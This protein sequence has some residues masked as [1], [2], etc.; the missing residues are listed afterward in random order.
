MA[1]AGRVQAPDLNLTPSL[2]PAPIVQGTMIQPFNPQGAGSNLMNIADSL[3]RLGAPLSQFAQVAQAANVKQQQQQAQAD[4]YLPPEVLAANIAKDPS[5]YGNEYYTAMAGRATANNLGPLIDQWTTQEW[6]STKED[7][8]TFVTRK[9]A[10]EQA[11]L[12]TKEAQAAFGDTAGAWVDQAYTKYQNTVTATAEM[13]RDNLI[14]TDYSGLIER[15]KLDKKSP[16]QIWKD[17]VTAS[18]ENRLFLNLPG[19]NQNAILLSL[20][21][22]VAESGDVDMANAILNGARGADGKTPSLSTIPDLLP[23]VESIRQKA[24][25]KYREGAISQTISAQ[26]ELDGMI[27]SG[28]TDED[29]KA[30]SVK[31]NDILTPDQVVQGYKALREGRDKLRMN[32]QWGADGVAQRQQIDAQIDQALLRGE[33]WNK[34]PTVE[35]NSDKTYGSTVQID[36]DK[37][38]DERVNERVSNLYNSLPPEQA[39]VETAKFLAA[40][41]R[42]SQA[43][44]SVFSAVTPSAIQ[45]AAA[46]GK[47]SPQLV[48][49]VELYGRVNGSFGG[50]VGAH[51]KGKDTKE[52]LDGVDFLITNMNRTPEEAIAIAARNTFSADAPARKAMVASE[53]AAALKGNGY[54]AGYDMASAAKIKGIAESLSMTAGIRGDKALRKAQE[55]FKQNNTEVLGTWVPSNDKRI[56]P[57]L[58][59]IMSSYAE[60]WV[61]THGSSIEPPIE[62]ASELSVMWNDG[63]LVLTRKEDGS[64]IRMPPGKDQNGPGQGFEIV[65]MQE[66]ADYWNYK[67]R[68]ATGKSVAEMVDNANSGWFWGLF[69]GNDASN[70]APAANSGTPAMLYGVTSPDK[71][72]TLNDHQLSEVSKAIKMGKVDKKFAT[73]EYANQ[74]AAEIKKRDDAARMKIMAITGVYVP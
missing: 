72:S 23:K 57:N 71:V 62:N 12:P 44:E 54:L 33:G 49:A 19:A 30:W 28:A 58:G 56:P 17:I 25:A 73:P 3:S 35:V 27:R 4:Q 50:I 59:E 48:R 66:A 55:I 29:F 13:N 16:D 67:N 20:A 47:V 1:Q 45:T 41:N 40:N 26:S 37:R 43:W 11:K 38:V 32:N 10:E 64:L 14:F 42:T 15:G 7:Y 52:F 46:E 70:P 24:E 36:V 68:A 5:K 69:G 22:K 63:R 74:I 21:D 31:H 51:I 39:D 53:V 9:L 65:T 61:T 60:D 6:D 34:F 2:Q 8:R 18:N